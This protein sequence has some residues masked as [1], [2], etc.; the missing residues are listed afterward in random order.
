MHLI[1]PCF[2]QFRHGAELQFFDAETLT[3]SSHWNSSP[4]SMR[5][6]V[7]GRYLTPGSWVSL[8]LGKYSEHAQRQLTMVPRL[9]L[10]IN[11]VGRN[12]GGRAMW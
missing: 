10:K 4:T 3:L 8:C 2:V 12:A 7:A 1:G 9:S 6:C 5:K 11:A